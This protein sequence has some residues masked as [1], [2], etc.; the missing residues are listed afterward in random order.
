[1]SG[2]TYLQSGAKSCRREK[3]GVRE[4]TILHRS[5]S[6]KVVQGTGTTLEIAGEDF[7]SELTLAMY[8]AMQ[9]ITHVPG[10]LSSTTS[11]NGFPEIKG[12]NV[13]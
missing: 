1:M 8:T 6:A 12:V 5:I 11:A 3:V 2:H 4:Q 9:T 10:P 7:C 13:T